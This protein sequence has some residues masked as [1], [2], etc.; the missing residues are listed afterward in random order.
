MLVNVKDQADSSEISQLLEYAVYSD[1]NALA[2][3]VKRYQTEKEIELYALEH[4]GELVGLIGYVLDD[5]NALNITHLAI[6]PE[7]RNQGYG[8]AIVLEALYEAK[9]ERIIAETDEDAVDFY[10]NIGFVVLS[11][12][13]LPNGIERFRCVYE[14]ELQED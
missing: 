6:V 4:E 12:G 9:P 5:Q 1:E 14:T 8:R 2:D 13:R 3:A 11:I 10:R 7:H